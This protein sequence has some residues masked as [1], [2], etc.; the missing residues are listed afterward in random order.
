MHAAFVSTTAGFAGF[1]WW[2]LASFLGA[3]FPPEPVPEKPEDRVLEERM[4]ELGWS[5]APEAWCPE[6]DRP[7]RTRLEIPDYPLW[8][9]LRGQ[10]GWAYIGYDIAASGQVRNVK[11]IAAAP[12]PRFGD[13][14]ARA[15]E[16]WAFAAGEQAATGCRIE[17]PFYIGD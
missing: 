1:L 15:V 13:A 2:A 6:E 12:D 11:I 17:F 8:H 9:E 14:A 7:E 3:V 16:Q 10:E 4:A 5:G